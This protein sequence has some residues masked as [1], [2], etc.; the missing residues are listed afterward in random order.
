MSY[1]CR[2]VIWIHISKYPE[3]YIQR[4]SYNIGA[5]VPFAYII[6]LKDMSKVK[7]AFDWVDLCFSDFFSFI[8]FF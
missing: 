6:V 1:I 5:M 7:Y 8:K 2:P 4:I 3:V